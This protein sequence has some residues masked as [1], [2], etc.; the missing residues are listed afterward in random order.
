M[1]TSIK[2]EYLHYLWKNKLL[3]IHSLLT[4]AGETIQV[5]DVGVHNENN[6]G[7]DF[8]LAKIKI[9]AITWCGS[10]EIHVHSSDWYLHNHQNDSAY[11]NVILHLVYIDNKPLSYH[12]AII[13]TVETK[14]LLKQL[15]HNEYLNYFKNKTAI[16]CSKSLKSQLLLN[17][18]KQE[19]IAFFQRL[20]RKSIQ[21][22][23]FALTDSF[24][25][26]AARAF[27]GVTNGNNF[28]NILQKYLIAHHPNTLN[29]QVIMTLINEALLNYSF[30][31]H[32]FIK[33]GHLPMGNAK[34][35]LLEWLSFTKIYR[36]TAELP[37]WE[38]EN[39]SVE[40]SIFR[41]K[42]K[43]KESHSSFMINNLIVNLLLP[44]LYRYMPTFEPAYLINA[45]K[46]LP[47][48]QNNIT[49]K[50]NKIGLD[51]KNAYES[52]AC[53]EIYQQFCLRK[54]CAQCEVGKK[55]LNNES[56]NSKNHLFL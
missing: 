39:S 6:S 41:L 44:F 15:H 26:L 36:L 33:K 34:K 25:L 2:E 11:N 21:H 38:K 27:G 48:E 22:K 30:N 28:E 24:Y 52:Q 35:R 18:A 49:R 19:E 16:L 54:Q 9:N 31:E 7:P 40:A 4:T 50:W 46:N 53:L 29:E 5:I 13:P 1:K 47:P 23:S 45:Y 17:Y 3:L 51:I 20:N 14:N 37:Y 56:A 10:V 8:L 43:L 42:H 55:L 32:Q 12:G